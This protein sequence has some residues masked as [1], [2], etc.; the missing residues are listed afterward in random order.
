MPIFV[1]LTQERSLGAGSTKT[2][3]EEKEKEEEEEE[4]IKKKKRRRRRRER[5][6]RS[7]S[8]LVLF[9]HRAFDFST[10]RSW[11]HFFDVTG[12]KIRGQT[13]VPTAAGLIG[14]AGS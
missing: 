8:S 7:R 10:K 2:R 3:E 11:M 1:A 12:L 6:G 13:F 14:L 4:E 5:K 9:F